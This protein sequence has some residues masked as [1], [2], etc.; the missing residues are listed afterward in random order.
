MNATI[1]QPA[2]FTSGAQSSEEKPRYDL[3][4]LEALIALAE[5]FGFGA[6]RHGARNYEKG[7]NDPQFVLD[8]YNHL[9]EHAHRAAAGD[10]SENHLAAVMCNAAMLIR[11]KALKEQ[12]R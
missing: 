9:L 3:I 1:D 5:R 10:T 11:L 4:P 6:T 2:V 12:A 7:Y 8:R